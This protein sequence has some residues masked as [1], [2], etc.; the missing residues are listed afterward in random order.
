MMRRRQ[1]VAG[2]DHRRFRAIEDIREVGMTRTPKVLFAL[3][4]VAVV[5]LVLVAWMQDAAAQSYPQRPIRI[6][7]PIAPGGIA[8]TF[9]R[10][11][12][13]RLFELW[14]QPVIV[15][16]KAGGGGNIGSD[17]V[18]KS[19]PDGYT[20]VM[21]YV[22]SHAVNPSLFRQMPYDP[23]RDFVPV[24]MVME[25]EGLLAVNP[26]VLPIR[27]VP[28]LIALARAQ[29]GKIAYS[30]GGIGTSSHLAG[31]L[32]KSMAKVDMV[33]VP[34]KGNVPSISDLIGGQVGLSFATM[35][36]VLPHVRAGKLR[37]IAV[38]GSERSVAVPEL[39][40][41]A[42][43]VP[44]FSVNN[45]IGLFAPA[46]TPA[47]IVNKL[48]AEV[49]KIME[50][51]DVQKRLESEGARFVKKT[52]EEFGQFVRAETVKWAKVLKDAGIQPE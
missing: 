28:E 35:P 5:A 33:H 30:S 14:G 39:P 8:D 19:A 29:P 34:Y 25:A 47:D 15:E 18:A 1:T 12:G 40:T 42:E 23:I 43:T 3:R 26:S 38:I 41:V 51:P 9:A 13:A 17:F 24:V 37:G 20:L 46:G 31:E 21:G 6:I 32:F 2:P 22:G 36:T 45:W 16:N 7:V 48:N 27:T 11:I 49:V 50:A 44:G 4:I 52:P 10:V